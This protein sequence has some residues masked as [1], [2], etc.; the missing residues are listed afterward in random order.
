VIARVHWDELVDWA[1]TLAEVEDW[2]LHAGDET[3]ADYQ[4]FADGPPRFD[5]LVAAVGAMQTR[6]RRYADETT[7]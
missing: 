7:T 3:I 5:D 2:L 4:S 6:I 1:T